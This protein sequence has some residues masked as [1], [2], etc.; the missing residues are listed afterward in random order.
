MLVAITSSSLRMFR[1]PIFSKALRLLLPQLFDTFN[2]DSLKNDTPFTT[3]LNAAEA[4]CN[5][6]YSGRLRWFPQ[7][8]SVSWVFL[9]EL[10]QVSWP[11]V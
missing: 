10:E 3:L 11:M 7:S 9:A 2:D 1:Y 5:V 8:P 6:G 4:G